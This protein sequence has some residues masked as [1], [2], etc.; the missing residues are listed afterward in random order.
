MIIISN[1]SQEGDEHFEPEPL[2]AEHPFEAIAALATSFLPLGAYFTEVKENAVI[3]EGQEGGCHTVL[4]LVGPPLE[5]EP[6][7]SFIY[8][9]TTQA[10]K[11]ADLPTTAMVAFLCAHI[12]ERGNHPSLACEVPPVFESEELHRAVLYACGIVDED[13]FAAGMRAK[14]PAIAIA[15][16]FAQEPGVS[17]ITELRILD[18]DPALDFEI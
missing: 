8:H 4:T 14:I 9:Y 13:D 15:A 1:F 3:L 11:L 5:M 7:I 6:V 16:F 12:A 2:V 18:A 17:F 10:E